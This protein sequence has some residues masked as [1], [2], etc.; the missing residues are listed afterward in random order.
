MNAILNALHKRIFN[1]EIALQANNQILDRSH[2]MIND[3]LINHKTNTKIAQQQVSHRNSIKTSTRN[4]FILDQNPLN[5]T[6]ENRLDKLNISPR[7]SF[8]QINP[9]NISLREGWKN[10]LSFTGNS[11]FNV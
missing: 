6:L 10:I 3:D 2:T 9:S 1:L 5:L 8:D 4:S 11:S 7:V